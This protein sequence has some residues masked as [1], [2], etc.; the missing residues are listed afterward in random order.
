MKNRKIY[1]T[2]PWE[3][4]FREEEFTGKIT[5]P[6]DIIVRN[7]YSHLSAGTEMACVAGLEDWFPLPNTPGYTAVG[8][9]IEKGSS[10]KHV[11]TGDMVFTFGPHSEYFK[12]NT[13]DRWHGVCVKVPDGLEPEMAAFTHM[14][15]IAMTSLRKSS[16]ELGDRVV[17]SGMGTIGNFAAQFAQLQGAEVLALDIIDSRLDIAESCGIFKTVNSKREDIGKTV[18]EF[19]EGKKVSTWIDATGVSAVIH[20]AVNHIAVNGELILLGSP[21]QSFETDIT[22]LL[23]KIHLVDNIRLKGAL[24]FLYPTRQT[25]FQ[26]HSIER[27]SRII[28]ELMKKQK[29]AVSPLYS[30]K[31][32]PAEAGDAYLGLRDK[33]EKFIGVVFDWT[34]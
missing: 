21:R 12:V 33:P 1:V 31:L 4:E 19:T 32:N 16:I 5:D 2:A 6:I 15:G 17:V 20:D 34:T 27:N 23:R 28:M 25:D 24:E 26:K 22:P 18:E 7:M 3:I 29:L 9:I 13:L 30:H 14:G 11:D 8:R 10:V